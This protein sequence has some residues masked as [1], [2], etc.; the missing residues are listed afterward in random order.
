M[1]PILVPLSAKRIATQML[2]TEKLNERK[3]FI[4]R[5][6]LCDI[7]CTSKEL[8]VQTYLLKHKN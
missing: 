2:A 6:F 4:L 1:L 8:P 3:K 5:V 7:I